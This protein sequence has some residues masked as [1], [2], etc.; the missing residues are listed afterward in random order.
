MG[1]T[2][3]DVVV[4]GRAMLSDHVSTLR[5][6]V[7]QDKQSVPA[8][9]RYSFS[10]NNI[11]SGD[12]VLAK[13]ISELRSAIQLLWNFKAR[14]PLPSW[15]A[16]GSPG[17]DSNGDAA[18]VIRASHITDLRRWLNQYEDNHAPKQ[19]GINSKSY[20]SNDGRH[21]IVFD[22]DVSGDESWNWVGA[23]RELTSDV[24]YGPIYI[25]TVIDTRNNGQSDPSSSNPDDYAGYNQAFYRYTAAFN[26][27]DRRRCG[28]VAGA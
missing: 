24:E 23:V 8:P 7:D 27:G 6:Y 5:T 2:Y 15:T 19:Q 26:K 10:W 16:A 12:R 3:T 11:V 21:P 20:S 25:R 14:G 1:R 22:H 18:T 13:Y 9:Y 17:G 4:G 28:T